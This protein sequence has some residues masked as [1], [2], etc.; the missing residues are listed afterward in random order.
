MC[1]GAADAAAYYAAPGAD[2]VNAAAVTVAPDPVVVNDDAAD[3]VASGPSRVADLGA[4]S[5]RSAGATRPRRGRRLRRRR[6]RRAAPGKRARGGRRR[7]APFQPRARRRTSPKIPGRRP[8]HVRCPPPC[9]HATTA[10]SFARR[11]YDRATPGPPPTADPA[12]G[13]VDVLEA[14]PIAKPGAHGPSSTAS[15]R[16]RRDPD[17]II[18]ATVGPSPRCGARARGPSTRWRRGRALAAPRRGVL[19]AATE[20]LTVGARRARAAAATASP[21]VIV[22]T[23]AG[24]LRVLVRADDADAA[25]LA[26]RL[27]LRSMADALCCRRAD[28]H[29]VACGAVVAGGMLVGA[30]V[31]WARRAPIGAPM[32]PSGSRETC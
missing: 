26:K 22:W 17:A 21:A 14:L 20:A 3:F 2:D 7:L 4:G 31:V 23:S 9:L 1:M 11:S 5:V 15:I 16:H 28:W 29:R 8:V 30:R 19:V 6:D 24:E 32:L 27:G 10:L 25:P 12:G 18:G 13:P